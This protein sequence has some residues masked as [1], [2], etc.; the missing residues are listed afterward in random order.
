MILNHVGDKAGSEESFQKLTKST[1][2]GIAFG[3]NIRTYYN[4][5]ASDHDDS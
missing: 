2:M 1:H 5:L 4:D 3:M